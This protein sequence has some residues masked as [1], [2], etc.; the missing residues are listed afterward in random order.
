[1]KKIPMCYH[2]STYQVRTTHMAIFYDLL[3]ASI[4]VFICG[5]YLLLLRQTEFS[6]TVI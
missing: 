6:R 5:R 3:V 2:V 4:V 1:M